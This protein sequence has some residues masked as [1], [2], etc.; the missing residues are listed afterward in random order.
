M[1]TVS[2][3]WDLGVF[4]GSLSIGAIVARTSYG[5]GFAAATAFTVLALAGLVLIERRRG[6]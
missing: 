5:A 4:A 3:A 6:T 1:G 2:G